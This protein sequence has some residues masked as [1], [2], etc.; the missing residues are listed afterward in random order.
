MRIILSGGGT[1]GSV[2]PLLAVAEE[3]EKQKP[4][5]EF[6]FIGTRQ[7]IPEKKLV[8]GQDIPYQSIFSGKLRRYLNWRN[9]IDPFF[10]IFGLIQSFFIILKFK[11]QAILSAGGFVA[12]PLS[13]A[14]W[15]LRVPIFIHQQDM[16]PG[17]ANKLMA[18]MAR[19]ITV[20]FEKSLADFKINK[21]VLTGNP[22]RHWILAG[23]KL[24]AIK[25]FNLEHN[26]PTILI[27]GGG[28]GAQKINQLIEEIKAQL[29]KSCQI[30]HCTGIEPTSNNNQALKV[31]SRYHSYK[32]LKKA[33]TDA[34]AIADVVISR[35]G[36]GVL[37][38]LS[39]LA[40]PT[41]LIP[42]PD[43]HQEFNAQYFAKEKAVVLFDQKNLTAQLLQEKIYQLI[44]STDQRS[45]LS[46]NMSKLVYPKAAQ[47]IADL[48]LTL[49][50]K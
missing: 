20:S 2:T 30:I 11:P 25:K 22:V 31:N 38:E 35:A 14:G 4:G 45:V 34:Y 29:T 41:I 17:L 44:A 43:S 32:F 46:L 6:L 36:M 16:I 9:M 13:W 15:F 1:G 47:K 40:K 18:P 42:I 7:G 21:T 5:I 39:F 33:M 26:L 27:L 24:R 28:T 50:K 19:K 12:V 8:E 48:V 49:I 3:L 23:N 37:T 10:I